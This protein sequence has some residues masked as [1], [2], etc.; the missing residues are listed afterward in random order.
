MVMRFQRGRSRSESIESTLE[1]RNPPRVDV[2]R[3]Q[4]SSA[5][6]SALL[7]HARLRHQ[8]IGVQ[9]V[10]GLHRSL[11]NRAV[12]RLFNP[13]DALAGPATELF[14]LRNTL[15]RKAEV[16]DFAAR[17]R[18]GPLVDDVNPQ[19]KGRNANLHIQVRAEFKKGDGLNPADAEYRQFVK[20]KWEIT[21]PAHRARVWSEKPQWEDDGYSRADD[22]KGRG[23]EAALF[24]A[25]DFPGWHHSQER[26]DQL[27]ATDTVNATFSAKQQIIDTSDQNRVIAEVPE[28]TATIS[29]AHPRTYVGVDEVIVGVD[30]GEYQ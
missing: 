27:L 16:K 1:L 20:D 3:G 26:Q 7:R 9:D 14:I 11:G 24:E 12:S 8:G 17:W 15:S 6:V 30:S 28:H 21:A 13:A 29:G 22:T 10:I 4:S 19:T 5:N 2:D 18:K 25:Q 23:K